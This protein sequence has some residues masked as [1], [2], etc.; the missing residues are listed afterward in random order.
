MSKLAE[1]LKSQ[2]LAATRATPATLLNSSNCSDCSSGAS[3]NSL[4]SAALDS[5]ISA[6]ARRWGYSAEELA[7]ALTGAHSDPL[8]WIAWTERD[9][10]DFGDCVT[11]EDFGEAYRRARGLE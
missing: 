6:M 1:L 4:L 10:R 9:E 11:P 7:E 3:E 5:R 8:G 2:C